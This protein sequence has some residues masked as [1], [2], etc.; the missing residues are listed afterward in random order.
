MRVES[1]G[2]WQ[3]EQVLLYLRYRDKGAALK[4]WVQVKVLEDASRDL[5]S[6][7]NTHHPPSL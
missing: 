7:G 1:N 2:S 5:W 6:R 4:V 3:R